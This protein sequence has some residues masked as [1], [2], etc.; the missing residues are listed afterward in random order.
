M[1][2]IEWYR[3][4]YSRKVSKIHSLSISNF[5]LSLEHVTGLRIVRAFYAFWQ[6]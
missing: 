4:L 5:L 1:T 3:Y 2:A 6:P